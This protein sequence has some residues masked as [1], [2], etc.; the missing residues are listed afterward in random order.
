MQQEM[1]FIISSYVR[2]Q[3][4]RTSASRLF[5]QKKEV[6]PIK[7]SFWIHP[8]ELNTSLS[9]AKLAI[10][11]VMFV[12]YSYKNSILIYCLLIVNTILKEKHYV[13]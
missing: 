2:T 7:I 6:E 1:L 13:I 4:H 12:N 3:Q 9:Q 10:S 11:D 8:L 5:E